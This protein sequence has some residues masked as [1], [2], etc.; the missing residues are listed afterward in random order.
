MLIPLTQGQVAEIDDL[1]YPLVAAFDWMATWDGNTWYAVATSGQRKLNL[2]KLRMHRL[3]ALPLD[4][5]EIDHV[6]RNG[7]H[8]RRSN[9]RIATRRQNTLNRRTE[10]TSGY[11]GVY[12]TPNGTYQAKIK[13]SGRLLHL[14]TFADLDDAARA[15]DEAAKQYN[16]RFAELNFI[17]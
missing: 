6:D 9:L 2:P 8:N 4:H 16:G 11:R 3:I 12:E 1:D 7:L 13:V 15:Y 17:C 14:G 10:S 5:Q